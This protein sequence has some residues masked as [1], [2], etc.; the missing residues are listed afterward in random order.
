MT[1]WSQ[2]LAFWLVHKILQLGKFKGSDFKYENSFFKYIAQKYSNQAFLVKNTKKWHF[3]SQFQA[4]LFLHKVWQLD[5]GAGA[6]FKYDNS[7][8]KL[9]PK[10]TQIKHFSSEIQAILFFCEYLQ[11]DKLEGADFKYDNRFLV[12]NTQNIIFGPKFRHFGF[13]TKI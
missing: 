9:Y 6:D 12:K 2:I 7:F 8:P 10:N 13:F 3:W 4:F 11:F 1:I 5:R